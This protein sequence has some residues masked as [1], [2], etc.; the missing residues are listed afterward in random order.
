MSINKLIK[1]VRESKGLNQQNV[2]DELGVN[3]TTIVRWETDGQ[4]IKSTQLKK[5]AEFYNT[6]LSDLYSFEQNPSMLEEPLEY[7]KTVKRKISVMVDL[8]GSS[9][10]LKE[11]IDTLTKVNSSIA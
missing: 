5:L 8:D 3:I 9:K 11:W 4:T 2:A 1:R 6:N 10:N 7:Y